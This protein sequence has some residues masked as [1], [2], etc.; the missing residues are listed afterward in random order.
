MLDDDYAVR[1][2]FIWALWA[3]AIGLAH[4]LY[5]GMQFL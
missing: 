5:F 2:D 1:S 4:G 3:G